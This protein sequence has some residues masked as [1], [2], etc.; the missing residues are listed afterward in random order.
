MGERATRAL[1]IGGGITGTTSAVVLARAGI[2]VEL[3]ERDPHWRALG[4][5]ITMIGPALRALDRV[6]LLDECLAE[7]FGVHELAIHDVAGNVVQVIPLPRLLGPERPG[8]LGMMRPTLHRILA[9]AATEAGASVRSGMRPTSIGETG[10]AVE[11]SLS[12]GTTDRYDVV[13][14]ADGLHSWV[15]SEVFGDVRP[16]F[17]HQGAFRAVLPRPADL[18]GSR[19]FHGH[20]DVHP[21]FTPTGP[22]TMYMFCVVPAREPVWPAR[23]DL[24]RLMREALADFGGSA[25]EA[26]EQITDPAMV[27]YRLFETLLVPGPWHRGRIVALGDA[28]HTTTPHLAAGAAMCLE[29]AV[30]LGEELEAD[31]SIPAA[32]ARFSARRHDRCKY[33]VDGSVQISHWQTH[34]GAADRNDMGFMVEATK[35]LAGAF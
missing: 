34:P 5:G 31:D 8:L 13:V 11:V 20:P 18:T 1:V 33:V 14:A 6:G 27:D 28:M 4:H 19:Q 15:R 21:G 25:A 26:R 35:V 10:D 22:D 2:D 3:V 7:G 30:V 23:E 12:D 16:A 32:L 17:Q 29:D 24:P 9:A